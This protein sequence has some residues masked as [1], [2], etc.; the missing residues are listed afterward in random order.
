MWNLL[1]ILIVKLMM[2]KLA[3]F[4]VFGLF[5]ASKLRKLKVENNP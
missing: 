4:A 1:K 3:V 5:F 2:R